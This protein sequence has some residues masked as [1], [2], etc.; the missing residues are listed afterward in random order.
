MQTLSTLAWAEGNPL[1]EYQKEY[2]R[3]QLLRQQA[4]RAQLRDA[5]LRRNIRIAGPGPCKSMTRANFRSVVSRSWLVTVAGKAKEYVVGE[6]LLDFASTHVPLLSGSITSNRLHF[7]PKQ[8]NT[9]KSRA[10]EHPPMP[11]R[12]FTAESVY[13]NTY[14]KKVCMLTSSSTL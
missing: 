2:Y 12:K 14:F 3:K 5:G 8:S 10:P 4:R 11:A 13:S 6:T 7:V 1:S 9:K